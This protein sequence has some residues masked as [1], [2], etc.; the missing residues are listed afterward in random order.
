[1]TAIGFVFSAICLIPL[2]AMAQVPTD[3]WIVWMS[4]RKDGRH[5]IFLMNAAG[6]SVTR[7]TF[8]GGANPLWS[9]DGRWISY[10][11]TSLPT[12]GHVIRWDGSMDK[13]VCDGTP[14]FWMHDNT[15]LVCMSGKEYFLVDPETSETEF[16]FSSDDFAQL[17]GHAFG[18]GGI[19]RDGKYLFGHSDSRY[20]GHKGDNGT[21]FAQGG[22]V[23]VVDIEDKGKLYFVGNGC[24]PTTSPSS[25]YLYHVRPG[26]IST[27]IYRLSVADLLTRSSYVPEMAINGRPF[28]T[29]YFPRVSTDG[30]WLTLSAS[31]H[32]H[33]HKLCNY[34]IF[35]HRL[36]SSTTSRI[37]LTNNTDNDTN[38]HMYVGKLWQPSPKPVLM[39][40]PKKI[41]VDIDAEEPSYEPLMVRFKN[42]GAG[43]IAQASATVVSTG[44]S[45]WLSVTRSGW[46]NSQRLHNTINIERLT[47]GRH[48]A[49]VAVDAKGAVKSTQL[50]TV[51]VNVRGGAD[52]SGA[53][54]SCAFSARRPVETGTWWIWLLILA[55]IRRRILTSGIRVGAASR[56]R[57]AW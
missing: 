47:N 38:P 39:V 35:V 31:D 45:T 26:Q 43:T 57:T 42:I 46:G 8:A 28:S 20:R 33:D 17:K 16:M 11:T 54:V 9:P 56:Q 36:D 7:L 49:I 24:G 21:Y 12:K 29:E 19:T 44:D 1:M 32:C 37:R 6:G 52:R 50:Y 4:N 15:G 13:E 18:G 10:A 51:V 34:E 55:L 27:D 40:A 14:M 48:E 22:A 25:D 3:G 23:M 30:K 2:C 5:E 41:M 53:G